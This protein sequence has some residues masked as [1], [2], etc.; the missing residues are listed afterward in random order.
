[1]INAINGLGFLHFPCM[2]HTLQLGILKAYHLVPVKAALARVSNTVNH[3]RC[4]CKATYSLKE[5]QYLLGLKP[6]MLKSSCV[7]RQGSTYEMLS[8][9]I[10][11]QQAKCTVLLENGGDC[12]LMPSSSKFAVIE[13]IVDILKSFNNATEILSG[14]LDPT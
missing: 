7:T 6:H 9:F 13:E 4:S 10:E 2:S 14:D 8:R 1:M 3:F 5:K 11:Q 12:V